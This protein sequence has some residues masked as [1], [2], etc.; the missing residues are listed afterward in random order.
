MKKCV[1]LWGLLWAGSAVQA[2][3]IHWLSAPRVDIGAVAN[4]DVLGL[5]L[6]ANDRYVSF[7]SE[8]SNLVP[9]DNNRQRDAFVLDLVSGQLTRSSVPLSGE[10]TDNGLINT[11]EVSSNGQHVLIRTNSSVYPNAIG[12]SSYGI[13]LKNLS[14]GVLSNVSDYNGGAD[15]FSVGGMRLM[16]SGDAVVFDSK[17]PID[18]LHNNAT[19]SQV[20]RKNLNTG[21]ITLL[22]LN[23]AGTAAA[24]DSVTLLDASPNGEWLLWRSNASDLMPPGALSSANNIFLY[25]SFTGAVTQV[26]V[27]PNGQ[28]STDDGNL[29]GAAVSN[30][31]TVVY[32]S[33]KNDL[34]AGDVNNAFDVFYFD[35]TQNLRINRDING[36]VL[37]DVFGYLYNLNISADGAR[38]VFNAV[39][40]AF[41]NGDAND[42]SDLFLYQ[43]AGGATTLLTQNASGDT[44]NGGSEVPVLN[45]DG[46]RLLFISTATDLIT[47]PTLGDTEKMYSLHIGNGTFALQAP[48]QVPVTAVTQDV[49]SRSMSADHRWVALVSKAVNLVPQDIGDVTLSLFLLDRQDDSIER[50]ARNVDGEANLSENGRF[51]AFSTRTV[52]PAGDIDLGV[53]TLYVYD[54]DTATF[55][56][57]A[58]GSWPNINDEGLLVFSTFAN[59][60]AADTNVN[61]LDVYAYHVITGELRLISESL[62]GNGGSSW[63]QQPTLTGTGADV[64][65]AFNSIADDLVPNDVNDADDIFLYRWSTQTL[66]RISETAAGVGGDQDS[67]GVKLSA[68]AELVVFTS[69]AKNLTADDLTGRGY[70]QVFIY[71]RLNQTME[72]VSYNE[73]GEPL[74]NSL[75]FTSVFYEVM[76]SKDGRHVVFNYSDDG[77]GADFSDDDDG[78]YDVYWLDRQTQQLTRISRGIDGTELDGFSIARDLQVDES[79]SPPRLGVLFTGSHELTGLDNYPGHVDS[80]QYLFQSGG[81]DLA[82]NIH[83][84]GPGT[85][86]G[87]LGVNCSGECT[88][89]FALGTELTLVAA[90]QNGAVFLGWQVD[91]GECNSDVNPCELLMDR[92]KTLTAEFFDESEIIFVHG[93]EV[94]STGQ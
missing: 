40:D 67:V 1:I 63:S 82:L 81:P 70:L 79:V 24:D 18:P 93:F 39:D 36:Q 94:P 16:A 23:D 3:A 27:Q 28:G 72:L 68:D 6:S 92:D 20:Y 77:S 88:E 22:S 83:V 65:I 17:T 66:E 26:T 5:Q 51:L 61:V 69:A 42:A 4:G 89:T 53:D 33:I 49:S 76:V 14:T 25:H 46:T 75:D 90:P 12:G 13:Y 19:D 21:A 55:T 29:I 35:G 64:W 50:I 87:T 32:Q 41:W 59:L 86:T 71:D 9:G 30:L 8:S 45:S 60:V 58:E 34:V 54:R 73:H 47:A 52:P 38:V 91:F 80:E 78:E 2:Q 44:P 10:F 84:S 85:V 15:Y 43:T 11:S 74:G 57:V 37:G 56:L 7:V 48:A 62:S 31:G